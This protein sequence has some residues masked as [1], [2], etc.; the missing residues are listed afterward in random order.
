M[1]R[2][3]FKIVAYLVAALAVSSANAGAYEDFFTAVVRNDAGTIRSLVARGFDPDS[4]NPKGQPA[5]VMAIQAESEGVVEALLEV[6][7]L[8]VNQVNHVGESAL[9]M[10]ALKGRLAWCQ[11]LLD[12][13]A[14]VNKNGWTPLHY[15]ATGSATS[16]VT[17]L[18]DK[19]ATLESES[20]NGS[21]PL[22]MAAGYGA[23]ANVDLLLGRGADPKRLND[24]KLSAA[25]FA[26]RAQ[27]EALGQRLDKLA[28]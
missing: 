22:M 4:L 24:L 1:R 21:T 3:L 28:R 2:N 13:G 10:A 27:R 14:E 12:R 23:E 11:K 16:I 18:I 20:P 26:R 9:M 25:D 6:P 19:G 7:T 15:A 5:I 17:L 8:D